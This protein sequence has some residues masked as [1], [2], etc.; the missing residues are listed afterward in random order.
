[1]LARVVTQWEQQPVESL[2]PSQLLQGVRS[3]FGAACTYFTEIQSTLPAAATSEVL[4][5]RLYDGLIKR[6]ADPPATTFL[7]GFATASLQA[8]KSLV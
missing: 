2:T 3:V 7:F 5:T 6:K 1:M 4:F 8:D